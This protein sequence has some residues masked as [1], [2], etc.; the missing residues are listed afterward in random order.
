[1]PIVITYRTVFFVLAQRWRWAGSGPHLRL[2]SNQIRLSRSSS[3]TDGS[4]VFARSDV[5]QVSRR[6]RARR[7]LL[8][9]PWMVMEYKVERRLRRPK[10]VGAAGLLRP[11]AGYVKVE[12]DAR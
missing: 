1:M 11:T 5:I 7:L 8:R 9:F 10:D 6:A 4:L 12:K 3:T 2:L